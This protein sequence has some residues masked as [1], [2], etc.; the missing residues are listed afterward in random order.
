MIF[1]DP[2][3]RIYL[4][5]WGH[6]TRFASARRANKHWSHLPKHFV[7]NARG[8][9]SECVIKIAAPTCE[10]CDKAKAERDP[11]ATWSLP[12]YAASHADLMRRSGWGPAKNITQ[13]IFVGR[14]CATDIDDCASNP[15]KNGGECDDQVNAF[16]CICPVGFTGHECEVR[17]S[18]VLRKN[19][20]Y[21]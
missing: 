13:L 8:G 1:Y 2:L 10:W 18:F 15:C 3:I 14:D 11:I 21:F 12:A 7:R 20:I 6:H 4:S 16:R 17:K 5:H 9:I 19:W